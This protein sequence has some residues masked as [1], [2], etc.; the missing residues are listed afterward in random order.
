MWKQ[1]EILSDSGPGRE[2]AELKNS[3]LPKDAQSDF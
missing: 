1:P 2:V 3:N